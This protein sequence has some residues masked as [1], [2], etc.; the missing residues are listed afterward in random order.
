MKTFIEY[1]RSEKK[2]VSDDCSRI[3]TFCVKC[4]SNPNK[5]CIKHYEKITNKDEDGIYV[6]PY[7]FYTYLKK[8][9]I[10]TSLI[11]R[12]KNNNKLIK[13]LKQN[14]EKVSD[15]DV[16]TEK[17]FIN[18]MNDIDEIYTKNI[19]L[20]DCMHDLR[21]MGGYFNSMSEIIELKHKDLAENDEDVRAMLALY[22]LINYRLN[23]NNGIQ[24]INNKRIKVKIYPLVK[25]LQVMMR[26]QARKKKI[27]FI[28]DFDQDNYVILSNNIYL[29][30]F[31]LMENAVKHSIE[32]SKVRIDFDETGEYTI[33]IISNIGPF[34]DNDEIEK[35]FKR[36]YRGKNAISKG[37]GIGLSMVQQILED[38]DYEYN[39]EIE[40]VNSRQ[41]LY[42]FNIK[43]PCNRKQ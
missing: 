13:N 27:E 7:G 31:I 6:C 20:R 19:E 38:Y 26:Y 22:D 30:I 36:G 25:K 40:K 8:N 15:Y 18:L 14:K 3:P 11:F 41:C 37:S 42:K 39:L 34:I 4:L 12:D 23:V 24:N 28:I 10:T 2:L 35:L 1:D 5:K 29:V 9:R 21:N 17:Q 16:Y 43:F 32:N 33:F